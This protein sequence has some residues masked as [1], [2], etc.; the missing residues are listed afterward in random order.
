MSKPNLF[1]F[2]TGELSQD[3]FIC[4]LASWADP[5]WAS[6]EQALHE[7]ATSFLGKLLDLGKVERPE[8]YLKVTVQRQIKHIDV[9]IEINDEFAI[10]VEDKTFT[11]EHSDQLARYLQD[12][13]K[14]FQRDKIAAIYLKTGDQG[15]YA[16][17]DS[18][19]YSRFRRQEFL[20]LLEQGI[21]RGVRNDIYRDFYD[22]LLSL[23][24]SIRA[25]SVKP[26]S[27]WDQNCWVGFFV[28]LQ[29]YFTD[30]NWWKVPNQSG[31]FMGF[32][33][34]ER[35]M[36]YLQLEEERLCVKI[37]VDDK[38]IRASKWEAW[39]SAL[40]HSDSH[41]GV[42]IKRPSHRRSGTSMTVGVIDEYRKADEHGILDL[43]ATI[44]FLRRAEELLDSSAPPM[45]LFSSS[46][47]D[48]S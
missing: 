34:H 19:G 24:Q 39:N 6:S 1:A 28:E 9:L 40:L 12:L 29:R 13:G 35:G 37:T 44:A 15:S 16:D 5:I 18:A 3:A 38:A 31:G 41:K 20:E 47:D 30:G 48:E 7:T 14:T 32:W 25:F 36:A 43:D 11:S 8:T 4:W 33:W 22:S 17:V 42:G 10:L 46:S 26:I 27:E 2:A 21:Q 45:E 23:D